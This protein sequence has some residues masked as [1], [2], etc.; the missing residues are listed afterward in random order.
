MKV[1][2]TARNDSHEFANRKRSWRLP[3]PRWRS[4]ARTA[5]FLQCA[6]HP[7]SRDLGRSRS[8]PGTRTLSRAWHLRCGRTNSNRPLVDDDGT[9]R[10]T[11]HIDGCLGSAAHTVA[12]CA[13]FPLVGELN[14]PF[15][16]MRG[17]RR[18]GLLRSGLRRS[19][20]AITRT[21]WDRIQPTM[22]M[23][24]GSR[25]SPRRRTLRSSPTIR[26]LS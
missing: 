18:V 20:K 15:R 24:Q 26:W 11:L 1:K 14:A 22:A 5:P 19:E 8:T 23:T 3:L 7:E 13:G 10:K 21:E 4:S 17:R 2:A 12:H 6:G 9:C 16:Q 25:S